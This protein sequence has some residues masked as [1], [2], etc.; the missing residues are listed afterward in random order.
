[1][2][3]RRFPSADVQLNYQHVLFNHLECMSFFVAQGSA[4]LKQMIEIYEQLAIPMSHEKER[5]LLAKFKLVM[6]YLHDLIISYYDEERN[7]I[8]NSSEKP[9]E[10]LSRIQ[11]E[12]ENT[13][14]NLNDVY[15]KFLLRF[16][17]VI[18]KRREDQTVSHYK[19]KEFWRDLK[20]ELEPILPF[21]VDVVD[22]LIQEAGS[23]VGSEYTERDSEKEALE[24]EQ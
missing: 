2:M 9:E 22:S 24:V 23:V 6:N 11:E 4:D 7:K 13:L 3:N 18:T 12:E 21:D 14:E 20:I 1:M 17:V 19:E 5:K 8:S 10:E 15:Y 16:L